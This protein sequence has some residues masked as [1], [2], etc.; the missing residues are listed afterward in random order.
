[1]HDIRRVPIRH[2]GLFASLPRCSLRRGF[3]WK[4][5]SACTDLVGQW[6]VLDQIDAATRDL[7]ERMGKRLGDPDDPLLVSVRSGAPFS[8]PGMMDTVLNLGLNDESVQGLI[9]QTENP[10]FAWDSYRRLIQMFSNVVL[11]VDADLLKTR[12]RNGA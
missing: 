1:M 2:G 4:R 6:G 7:E 12:C 5:K 3:V 9:R 8:V 10:R 11:G